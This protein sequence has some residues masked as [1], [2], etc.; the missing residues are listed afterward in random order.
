MKYTYLELSVENFL[1]NQELERLYEE[2]EKLRKECKEYLDKWVQ[3][4]DLAAHRNFEL[5]LKS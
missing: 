5:A 3:A 4:Q 2:N 1:L